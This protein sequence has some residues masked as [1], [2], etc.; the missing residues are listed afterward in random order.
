LSTYPSN[1]NCGGAQA[2]SA[3]CNNDCVNKCDV[4]SPPPGSSNTGTGRSDGDNCE[5]GYVDVAVGR[6]V[7]EIDS[8]LA[9]NAAGGRTPTQRAL[10]VI[11]DSPATYGIPASEDGRDNYILLITDGEANCFGGLACVDACV[12]RDRHGRVN[13]CNANCMV[14]YELDRLRALAHPVKT[15]TVGFAFSSVSHNLNCNAVHGGTSL[16][17]ASVDASNCGSTSNACYYQANSPSALATALNSITKEIAGGCTLQLQDRPSD[18]SKL[19][20]FFRVGGVVQPSPLTLG[21]DYTYDSTSN[22]IQLIG[23][24]CN[25]VKN[26]GY[27]PKVVYG[28]PNGGS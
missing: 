24:A 6:P 9:A 11:A 14:G 4:A 15:F 22:Q 2:C 16:C 12:T 18:P 13:G 27:Q 28:C 26:D 3:N 1:D 21:T 10:S 8:S 20:V 19:Y 7:A 5:P 17:D 25:H 23:G